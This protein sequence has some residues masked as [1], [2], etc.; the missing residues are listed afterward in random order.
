MSVDTARR[1]GHDTGGMYIPT[2]EERYSKIARITL[3]LCVIVPSGVVAWLGGETDLLACACGFL[4][5]LALPLISLAKMP[6][7]WALCLSALAQGLAYYAVVRSHTLTPK[8]KVTL[9]ITWGMLFALILR[10]MIAYQVWA[11]V[12]GQ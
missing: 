3:F 6:P 2:Q 4:W 11:Q 1:I 9:T 5:P 12:T 8:G 7:L 10:V